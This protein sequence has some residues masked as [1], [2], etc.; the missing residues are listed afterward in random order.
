MPSGGAVGRGHKGGKRS[1]LERLRIAPA[2]WERWLLLVRLTEALIRETVARRTEAGQ[3]IT[4][5]YF[6]GLAQPPK[7]VIVPPD[8]P[9]GPF[10]TIV[11]D[12]PWPITK[13]EFDRRDA[14]ARKSRV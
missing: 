8:F 13:I 3:G 9:I 11:I 10:R 7:P 6:Y 2:T 5:G 4:L 1:A 14:E 12:P